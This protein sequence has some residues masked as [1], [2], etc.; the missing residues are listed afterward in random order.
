MTDSAIS[1]IDK[2]PVEEKRMAL[3]TVV[4]PPMAVQGLNDTQIGTMKEVGLKFDKRLDVAL[5]Q[6]VYKNSKSKP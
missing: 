1:V 4:L 3:S 2:M 6:K 5:M